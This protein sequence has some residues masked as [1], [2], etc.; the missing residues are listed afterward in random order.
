MSSVLE[1][2]LG[3]VQGFIAEARRTRDYWAGSFL[4]SWL[5]G[6]AMQ[7]ARADGGTV[8]LPMIEGPVGADG[9]RWID[10]TIAALTM[11]AADPNRPKPF[12]GTLIN[13]FVADNVKPETGQSAACALRKAWV[14]LADAVR[15][16][17]LDDFEF[18]GNEAERVRGV[19]SAQIGNKEFNPFWEIYAVTYPK[20]TTWSPIQA[21]TPGEETALD[22]RKAFRFSPWIGVPAANSGNFCTMIGGLVDISGLERQGIATNA[23]QDFRAFWDKVRG[24]LVRARYK[25]RRDDPMDCL[26]LRPNESLS[27]PA[28]VKRLFPLLAIVNRSKLEEIVGWVPE[29][30]SS[31]AIG[32]LIRKDPGFLA[33]IRRLV[34]IDSSESASTRSADDPLDELQRQSPTH[35]PSTSYMAAAHWIARAQRSAPG[36]CAKFADAI[37]AVSTKLGMAEWELW[38]RCVWNDY[39][40]PPEGERRK[41]PVLFATDGAMFYESRLERAPSELGNACGVKETIR[42]AKGFLRQIRDSRLK[43]PSAVQ[44]SYVSSDSSSGT[45]PVVGAP[46]SYYALVRMDG[47]FAG[48]ALAD[49]ASQQP[50]SMLFNRFAQAVRGSS[51]PSATENET[52]G[53]V[54]SRNGVVLFSGGDELLALFPPEDAFHAVQVLRNRFIAA[55]AQALGDFPLAQGALAAKLTIS[56]AVLFAH[57]RAPLGWAIREVGNLLD[58][59]AKKAVGRDTLA[60]AVLDGDGLRPEWAAKWDSPQ[61]DAFASLLDR[62][63]HSD[64][65]LWSN[66]FYHDLADALSAFVVPPGMPRYVERLEAARNNDGT[67]IG[68]ATDRDLITAIIKRVIPAGASERDTTVA[69]LFDLLRLSGENKDTTTRDQQ[70][71]VTFPGAVYLAA[72]D[73]LRVLGGNWCKDTHVERPIQTAQAEAA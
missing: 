23:N 4:L 48:K 32:E 43:L 72:L 27:A 30:R 66:Q 36:K 38:L 5:V 69:A 64:G 7:A 31:T 63:I 73:I 61:V 17:V 54:A 10:P 42:N 40:Y 62:A 60:M 13:N 68:L 39:L 14:D 58:N 51:D 46:P 47:D 35:W 55:R 15:M 22:R 56:G 37:D 21:S 57:V 70:P 3:P 12:L 59:V 9:T 67:S 16:D 6:K 34:E 24:Q 53:E 19:W 50:A 33:R 41:A 29:V 2:H 65:F 20:R 8:R 1:F 28:L 71:A 25:N 26:D 52:L 49:P 45:V 18:L 11:D 44:R